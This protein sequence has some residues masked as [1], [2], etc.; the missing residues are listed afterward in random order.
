M[1]HS[2]PL[3][4]VISVF[5]FCSVISSCPSFSLGNSFIVG[6]SSVPSSLI[7]LSQSPLLYLFL[8]LCLWHSPVPFLSFIPLPWLPL[9][10]CTQWVQHNVEM[11]CGCEFKLYI[12]ATLSS[13]RANINFVC[14]LFKLWRIPYNNSNLN[15]NRLFFSVSMYCLMYPLMERF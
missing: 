4:N 2:S 12:F 3:R 6:G 15:S 10:L 9:F 13:F 1:P 14:C 7:S 8:R 11:P 5:S